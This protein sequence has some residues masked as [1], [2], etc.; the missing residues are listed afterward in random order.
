M[1]VLISAKHSANDHVVAQTL[2][3]LNVYK[4]VKIPLIL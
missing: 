3:L 1:L 2:D 4:A